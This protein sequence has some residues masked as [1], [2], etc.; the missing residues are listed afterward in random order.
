MKLQKT[1]RRD[2]IKI[3]AMTAATAALDWTSLKEASMAVENKEEYPVVI[4]GSGLGGLTC[5]AYLSKAGFPVT[6]VEQHHTPGGYA[7]A[8]QRGNF[9]FEVSLHAVAA[10]NNATYQMCNDLGLLSKV[11]FVELE[12]AH[13]LVTGNKD[14]LLP[15]KDPEAYIRLL[16]DH[17]PAEKEGIRNFV[18]EMLGIQ[19]EVHK[20]FLNKNEYITLFFPLQYSKMWAVRNKTLADLLNENVA[21]PELKNVLSFLSGYYGLPPSKLSGFYYANS[22]ADYLK[23]GSCYVRDRSQNLSNALVDIIKENGGTILLNTPAEKIMANGGAVS[24]VRTADGKLLPAKFVVSNANLPDTFGKLLSTDVDYSEYSEKLAT[25]R[26]SISS[27]SIWLGLNESLRGK[28]PGCCIHV[29]TKEGAEVAY[30]N[31]LKCDPEKVGYSLTLF[32]NYFDGY[33]A[34]SKSTVMI[35]FLSGYEPWKEFEKEYFAGRKKEYYQRKK[36]ITESLLRR[37]ENQFIP[38][39]SSMIEEQESATPLTNIRFTRN[40]Q[41]A[42]YGYE[43][44]MDNQFIGRIKNHTPIEGLYQASAWGYPGGGYEG[45]MRS[46]LG[47]FRLIVESL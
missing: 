7:T 19:E 4:I 22:V 37:V 41:G 33:S 42:I 39:L 46:G 35:T 8:F 15:D 10:K 45:V 18:T 3:S 2:F 25:L 12:K 44:A 40:P 20:L 16:S 47:T 9:S 31:A 14:L 6:V 23:N 21:D 24:G 1:T 38:G 43:Q 26:P 11:E 28:I 32:D 36:Q 30:Q 34:P 5:A 29:K 17:Y 27:F 13:R